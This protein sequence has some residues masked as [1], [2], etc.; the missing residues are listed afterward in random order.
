MNK[1]ALLSTGIFSVICAVIFILSMFLNQDYFEALAYDSVFSYQLRQFGAILILFL[2]GFFFFSVVSDTLSPGWISMLAFPMGICLWVFVSLV[3]LLLGI[4]Y[5]L[6]LTSILLT[7]LM[8]SLLFV[9]HRT[10]TFHRKASTVISAALPFLLLFLGFAFIASSGFIYVFVSYDSYFYFTNYGHTLTIIQNFRD[11]VGENSFTLTNISQFLPLLNAYTAFWG[12]DQCFQ[13]QAFLAFNIIACFSYGIYAYGISK[14]AASKKVIFISSLFTLLLASSTSFI[15]VSS[16]VLANMY[17]MAYIFLLF[18]VSFLLWE[19]LFSKK[20]ALLI[21]SICF[22]ALT[23]L[24][25]D[26]I[27]FA[28][29][30]LICFCCIELF[31][32]KELAILFLPAVFAELW[33][34]FYVR[35]VLNA[36]VSQAAFTSIANNKNVFFILLIIACSYIY[37]FFAHDLFTWISC[38]IKFLSEY[39]ILFAGMFCLFLLSFLKKADV[40]IDNVDFVIRN[41]FLY[42]SSWGISGIIFGILLVLSLIPKPKLDYLHFFWSGYAFLNLISYCLVDSK[43]FWVNW[44]D[45]YNRVLLQIVPVFVF[46]MAVKILPLLQ[47]YIPN[48]NSES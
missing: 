17:C 13:M 38:K 36:Q 1:K 32:K 34:L 41:M 35:I 11:I 19:K 27:I 3:L 5:T 45:S 8:V 39:L 48:H 40:I 10:T 25:K 14:K 21:I 28:A 6:W 42:P 4:P 23:L 18:I 37:I 30:F 47:S 15:I 7:A 22:T 26:G 46:I 43:A 9:R 33:W 44:D 2:I 29:F 16:W 31:S 24:R 12:L 20:D